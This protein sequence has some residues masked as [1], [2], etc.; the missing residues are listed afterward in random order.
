MI[1]GRYTAPLQAEHDDLLML[2]TT[3]NDKTIKRYCTLVR[4]V[5]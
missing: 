3:L 5:N 2:L 4:K 1:S